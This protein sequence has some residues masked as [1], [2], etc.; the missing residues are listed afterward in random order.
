MSTCL[1]ASKGAALQ[2]KVAPKRRLGDTGRALGRVGVGVEFI[3][4]NGHIE[5]L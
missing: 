5:K 4:Q 1:F 3:K 2:E